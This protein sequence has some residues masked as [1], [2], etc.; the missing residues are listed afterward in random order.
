MLAGCRGAEASTGQL[1]G[2]EG[3]EGLPLPLNKQGTSGHRPWEEEPCNT[4]ANRLSSHLTHI[5]SAAEHHLFSPPG[6][7]KCG[8]PNEENQGPCH[9]WEDE[10]PQEKQDRST[11]TFQLKKEMCGEIPRVSIRLLF[12]GSSPALSIP[13][14]FSSHTHVSSPT[15]CAGHISRYSTVPESFLSTQGVCVGREPISDSSPNSGM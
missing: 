11:T 5:L 8:E 6:L 10:G 4:W 2:L 12:T 7:C 1:P 15:V 13:H 14:P 3:Q 9:T